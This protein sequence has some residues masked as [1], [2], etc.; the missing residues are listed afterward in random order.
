VIP[1]Q[2]VLFNLSAIVGSAILYG[3]FRKT[4]FH[5]FVT[6]LYGCGAT[7]AGVFLIASGSGGPQSSTPS[8][9]GSTDSVASGAVTRIHSYEQGSPRRKIHV[10]RHRDSVVSLVSSPAQVSYHIDS[11]FILKCARTD[12]VNLVDHQGL[13]LVHTPTHE[14]APSIRDRDPER[15]VRSSPRRP[16]VR[17][18]GTVPTPWVA[19]STGTTPGEGGGMSASLGSHVGA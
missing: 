11:P 4:T 5:Q 12:K 7:F 10:L 1:S 8:A 18:R 2:F 16:V 13:L 19:N 14:D 6:F 17:R 3:D 15:S 9:E